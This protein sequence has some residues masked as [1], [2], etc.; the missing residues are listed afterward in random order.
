MSIVART[1]T[2]V[3]V[4]ARP[5]GGA[6]DLFGGVQ[7]GEEAA[8]FVLGLEPTSRQRR[9]TEEAL[10]MAAGRRFILT[11]ELIPGP[12]QLRER[13]EDEDQVRIVAGR[14]EARRWRIGRR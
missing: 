9:I 12:S 14:R 6:S 11:A 3:V 4:G 10:A 7:P 8:L 2:V 1:R 13:L 5:R